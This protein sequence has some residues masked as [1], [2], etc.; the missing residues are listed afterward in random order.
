M[1]RNIFAASG[2]AGLFI[3]SGVMAAE[4]VRAFAGSYDGNQDIY[5]VPDAGGVP[6]V[7]PPMSEFPDRSGLTG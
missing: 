5:T 2:A 1:I 4:P 6:H 3:A 7:I